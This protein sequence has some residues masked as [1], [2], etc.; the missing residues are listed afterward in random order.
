MDY[1]N[2]KISLAGI[3]QK[4]AEDGTFSDGVG[5]GGFAFFSIASAWNPAPGLA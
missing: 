3:L 4:L 1:Y 2:V 5:V